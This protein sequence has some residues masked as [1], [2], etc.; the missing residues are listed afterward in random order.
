MYSRFGRLVGDTEL[1]PVLPFRGYFPIDGDTTGIETQA[2]L[3][4]YSEVQ[5]H[6]ADCFC[7]YDAPATE[8]SPK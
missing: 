1:T 8:R 6:H 7:C 4:I 5:P 2:N 3:S